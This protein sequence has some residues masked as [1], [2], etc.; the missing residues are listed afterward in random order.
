[1]LVH[2]EQLFYNFLPDL[3]LISLEN[4]NNDEDYHTTPLGFDREGVQI[5]KQNPEQ[6]RITKIDS[7]SP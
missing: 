5:G 4:I 3:V 2:F 1:M 6:L 7:S